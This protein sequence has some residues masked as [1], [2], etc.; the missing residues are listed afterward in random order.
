MVILS[1]NIGK[2]EKEKEKESSDNLRKE[3]NTIKGEIKNLE[4]EELK[5][6]TV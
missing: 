5:I 3:L 6:E 4:K 2:S 1:F